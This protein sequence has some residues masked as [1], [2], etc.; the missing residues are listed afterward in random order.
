MS[1][2]KMLSVEL[3]AIEPS[4]FTEPGEEVDPKADIV[5]GQASD[6]LKRIYT[7]TEKL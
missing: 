5:V 3:S 1:W 6:D 7:L 2:L 4:E